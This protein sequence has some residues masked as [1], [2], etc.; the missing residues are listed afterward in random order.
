V[1]RMTKSDAL[2]GRGEGADGLVVDDEALLGEMQ[3]IVR[4]EPLD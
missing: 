4:P 1:L 3:V 2:D